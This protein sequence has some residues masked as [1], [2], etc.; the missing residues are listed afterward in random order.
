[1]NPLTTYHANVGMAMYSFGHFYFNDYTS[2]LITFERNSQCE[3]TLLSK[4]S[5]WT[6][7]MNVEKQET[8]TKRQ[9]K[10]KYWH[11]HTKSLS[12][13]TITIQ[14]CWSS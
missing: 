13:T 12:F 10:V 14:P 2:Y 5:N 7:V 6:S 3:E 8:H 4:L 11:V 9:K 1:M